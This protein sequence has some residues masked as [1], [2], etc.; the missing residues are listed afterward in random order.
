MD[1]VVDEP[2]E[3]VVAF[4]DAE[5][6]Q[7][8]PIIVIHGSRGVLIGRGGEADRADAAAAGLD[9]VYV[10]PKQISARHCHIY[11]EDG[12][13]YLKQDPSSRNGVY[14]NDREVPIGPHAP[15]ELAP[16][17]RIHLVRHI[18]L[19]EKGRV[20]YVFRLGEPP[21]TPPYIPP[22][23][24][25][26]RRDA[27][28]EVEDQLL[29]IICSED[30]F[31]SPVRMIPCGHVFD[32]KCLEKWLHSR[33]SCPICRGRPEAVVE[34]ADMRA[35]VEKEL[36]RRPELERPEPKP[37]LLPLPWCPSRWPGEVTEETEPEETEPE[38][39]AT[40]FRHVQDGRTAEVA[41]AIGA[42]DIDVN[43]H[44][45]DAGASVGRPGTAL[46]IAAWMGHAGIV[47][48]LLEMAGIDPNKPNRPGGKTALICAAEK[49]HTETVSTLLRHEGIDANKADDDGDTALHF[50]ACSGHAEILTALLGH[51]GIDANKATTLLHYTPLHKAVRLRRTEIVVTL[52]A[53]EGIDANKACSRGCTP[54]ML[55]ARLG[56]T[57]IVDA[58]LGH[59]GIDAN[60]ADDRGITALHYA[61]LKGGA[62]IV[63]RFLGHEGIDA[64]KASADGWTALHFAAKAGDAEIV[65]VLRALLEHIDVNTVDAYG[66]TA[67]HCAAGRGSVDIVIALLRLEGIDA[68][69]A[70]NDGQ[71]ALHIAADHGWTNP[72]CASVVTALLGHEGIDANKA[73]NAGRTALQLAK[74]SAADNVNRHWR[75]ESDAWIAQIVSQLTAAVSESAASS[76]R[77]VAS[78]AVPGPSPS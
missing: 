68:N 78:D 42:G 73:D 17:D 16:G 26:D 11:R 57:E 23:P 64:T 74:I 35:R 38:P 66:S 65:T 59:E 50:V 5:D 21:A 71:T 20:T 76:G 10:G 54:L 13:W 22:T 6:G 32:A 70:N 53:H 39:Y 75:G 27:T 1:V 44:A 77:L 60:K 51:E 62:Q 3:P 72:G 67:L 2:D 56:R 25:D 7:L 9:Y 40:L 29:C 30:F 33:F 15:A 46:L 47:T 41:V 24:A 55:A 43:H 19:P 49:G 58:L 36:A 12:K 14:H 37:S 28:E 34:A 31:G 48:A 4:L 52:L 18:N 61:A 45:R 69:K 8:L 63:V